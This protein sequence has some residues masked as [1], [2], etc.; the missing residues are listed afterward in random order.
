[1][2]VE[3]LVCLYVIYVDIY[4]CITHIF[5]SRVCVYA[6]VR[7]LTCMCVCVCVY[8]HKYQQWLFQKIVMIVLYFI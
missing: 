1:M 4:I 6:C 2:N 5:M 7:A 3:Y 8:K